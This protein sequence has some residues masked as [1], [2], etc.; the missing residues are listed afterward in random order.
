MIEFTLSVTAQA[1]IVPPQVA[2]TRVPRIAHIIRI[3]I[4]IPSSTRLLML[5]PM[6]LFSLSRSSLSRPSSLSRSWRSSAAR[7]SASAASSRAKIDGPRW[8][9]WTSAALVAGA[10][11]RSR[12]PRGA[13]AVPLTFANL[14][15]AAA[16]SSSAARRIDPA[17]GWL[18]C[19]QPR[20]GR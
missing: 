10:R 20:A 2:R 15:A 9:R 4:I 8:L 18:G 16:T 12:W 3:M 13:L 6:S 7:K 17:G 11:A 1:C 19:M 14:G 5:R